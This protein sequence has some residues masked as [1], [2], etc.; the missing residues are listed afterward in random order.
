MLEHIPDLH[1]TLE[2]LH[3]SLKNDGTIFI[4]V[5]NYQS[6]DGEHYKQHW[7]GYDVPRHLWHFSKNSMM[8]LLDETG[9]NVISI[10]P[11]KLDAYYVSLLS[12]KKRGTEKL[13]AL[14]KAVF[15]GFQS[16]NKSKS[17]VNYSSLIYIAKH[18]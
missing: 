16:N 5:P 6:P 18:K 12:E 8:K 17:S 7:A 2:K 14:F 10:H 1:Q 4:A 9:F 13:D 15:R 3:A 11:M